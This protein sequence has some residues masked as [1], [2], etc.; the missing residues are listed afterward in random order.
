MANH[1]LTN[2]GTNRTAHGGLGKSVTPEPIVSY[3]KAKPMLLFRHRR[4]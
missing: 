2:E 1:Q 4:R 3:L